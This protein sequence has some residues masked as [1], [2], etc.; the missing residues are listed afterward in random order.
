MG[1]C[2]GHFGPYQY[3]RASK[4]VQVPKEHT[5]IVFPLYFIVTIIT[6]ILLYV[7]LFVCSSLPA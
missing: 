1:S 4:H 2:F 6:Y 3:G 5:V 7:C